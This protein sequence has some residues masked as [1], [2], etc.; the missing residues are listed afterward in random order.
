MQTNLAGLRGECFF[1]SGSRLQSG[2]YPARLLLA[3][4]SAAQGGFA[5][6]RRRETCGRTNG[7]LGRPGA[8]RGNPRRAR[9]RRTFPAIER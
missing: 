3:G 2:N 1:P 4:S 8:E 9:A 7:G 6:S 5:I